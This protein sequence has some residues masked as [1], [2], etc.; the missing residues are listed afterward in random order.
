VK[1]GGEQ[2][3][4]ALV[5]DACG[6]DQF[7]AGLES[8]IEGAIHAMQHMWE[9]NEAEEEW[10]FLLIDAKNAFNEQNRTASCGRLGM[11]GQAEQGL[12]S[13]A[14]CTGLHS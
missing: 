12:P 5:K 10:G 13:T 3:T 8:G 14:T 1:L 9:T 7:C 6:I 4:N 2:S 11:S